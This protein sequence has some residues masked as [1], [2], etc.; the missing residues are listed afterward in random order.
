MFKLR[1]HFEQ[2]PLEV[3]RRI[4]EEQVRRE[5]LEAILHEDAGALLAEEENPVSRE[6]RFQKIA[7]INKH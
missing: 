6:P 1:T 4:V 5:T 2:V 3:V 7:T